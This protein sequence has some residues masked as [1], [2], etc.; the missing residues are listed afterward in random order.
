M[1]LPN[2]E[3]GTPSPSLHD[4]AC[5]ANTTKSHDGCEPGC[6]LFQ[7]CPTCNVAHDK[8]MILN[9]KLLDAMEAM[10]AA[11]KAGDPD[12]QIVWYILRGTGEEAYMRFYALLRQ[13]GRCP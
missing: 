10:C 1:S 5:P 8:T 7:H 3:C 9:N 4:I 11:L 12:E 13:C 6:T 2:C